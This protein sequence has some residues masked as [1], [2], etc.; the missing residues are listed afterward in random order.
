MLQLNTPSTFLIPTILP[1]HR[2]REEPRLIKHLLWSGH[3]TCIV[4]F[5]PHN[6]ISISVVI[7]QLRKQSFKKLIIKHLASDKVAQV[8]WQH[9]SA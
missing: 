2:K 3:F 7:Q 5:D 9:L 8:E 6:K 4:S 1:N